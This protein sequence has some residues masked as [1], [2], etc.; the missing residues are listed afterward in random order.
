MKKILSLSLC[1]IMIITM[2]AGCGKP[3]DKNNNVVNGKFTEYLVAEKVGTIDRD[4]FTTAEGGLFYKDDNGLYG[5][6]SYEGLHDTGAIYADVQS[7]GKYFQ[8]YKKAIKS[9]SDIEGINASMLI[10]GKGNVII[11]EGY[12]SFYVLND[13][14][15]LTSKITGRTYSEDDVVA[16]LTDNG[17]CVSGKYISD[18]SWYKGSWYVYDVVN[19]SFVPNATGTKDVT[20]IA[21]GQY[22]TFQNDNGENITID[23]KG[24]A[25]PEDVKMF[26][27]GSY[28]I[29]SKIGEVYDA[30]GNKLFAYDLTG[31]IPSSVSGD[32]YV[33]SKY[34]DGASKQAIMDK[35]GNV[36]STEFDD[37][38]T[39]YGEIVKCG[40]QIFNLKGENILKGE[41]ESVYYDDMFG[42]N[43]IVRNEDYYTMIDKNGAVFFNGPYDDDHT[44]WTD[45]F[46]ASEK[47]EDTNY[48]YSYKDRDYTIPGYHFAPW[49]VETPSSNYMY[50]LVDTMTGKKLLEGYSDYS[51][52]S[53]NAL[54]YYVYAEYNGGADVYLVVS[55][56][57]LE[58]V[59]AKKA[60]L[61]NDLIAAFKTE[62]INVTVNTENGEISLDSSVLFGGDSSELTAEGK[63]FL[64]KFI[65][66]Y[67]SVVYSEKYNG[68]ISKTMVE[69]HTA[70][71][72]GSTYA[73]GL[74]L[75]Q[76]RATNVKNYCLSEET[77]VN[78]SGIA[79]TFEDVGYSNSQP[80][81]DADGN[82]DMAASRR[83]SFRFLV[84]IEF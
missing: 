17:T 12:A 50:D 78:V 59:A 84:N 34:V 55:S 26:D 80:V 53:R 77:N 72:E 2:F 6:M 13:R 28:K 35:K 42:Q 3:K 16:S 24:V 41:Y 49:I 18:A 60:N 63:S 58:E 33:A 38:I 39:V 51:H 79:D 82:V 5:V 66:A 23:A 21:R 56:A 9:S 25:L 22:L 11:P 31:F 7:R 46:L 73:S 64:N 4:N 83:V 32:Y 19:K 1:I 48:Y 20:V 57:Q 8:V 10:D 70:P 81:Y 74:Q 44:V 76:E 61:F 54:A 27:D 36:I 75:S 29:E 52:I 47:R 65:K 69:G 15:I 45:D 67:T 43:W 37:Y 14:Y 62:G 40:N 71:V 30:N 68:F